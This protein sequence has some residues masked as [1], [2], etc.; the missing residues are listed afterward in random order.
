M[1]V[2][3]IFRGKLYL[4]FSF[5]FTSRSKDRHTPDTMPQ[6]YANIQFLKQILEAID[7]ITIKMKYR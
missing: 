7:T 4:D 5:R 3:L 6:C 1:K 2:I